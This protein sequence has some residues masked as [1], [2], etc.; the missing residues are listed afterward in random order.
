MVAGGEAKILYKETL[1]AIVD[2]CYSP[3]SAKF[4]LI[5]TSSISLYQACCC[6]PTTLVKPA[7][8]ILFLFLAFAAVAG[9]LATPNTRFLTS[10]GSH[11]H[12]AK[13][14]LGLD[15]DEYL[16][17]HN[18]VRAAHG[19]ADLVSM[20]DRM[21]ISLR[22]SSNWRAYFI[23]RYG[24]PRS[25]TGRPAG[26]LPVR[27]NTR[28]ARCLTHRTARTSSPRPA[29]LVFPRPSSSLF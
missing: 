20:I 6:S 22:K 3:S 5:L 1:D 12:V 26:P 17:A 8:M 21:L 18:T 11:A 14:L 28:M 4:L 10:R 23:S 19:V 27:S 13:S 16:S 25:Q 9:A 15:I 24:T 2:P 7:T 29:T